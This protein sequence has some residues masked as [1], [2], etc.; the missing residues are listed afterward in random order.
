[1]DAERLLCY[2]IIAQGTTVGVLAAP[3]LPLHQKWASPTL[4]DTI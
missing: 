1:V 2:E 4:V 3:E